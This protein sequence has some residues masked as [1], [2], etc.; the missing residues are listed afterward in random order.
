MDA[1]VCHDVTVAASAAAAWFAR[2]YSSSHRSEE[3]DGAEELFSGSWCPVA[4]GPVPHEQSQVMDAG[5][6]MQLRA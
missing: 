2:S 5:E 3:A 6:C 4:L 1:Q